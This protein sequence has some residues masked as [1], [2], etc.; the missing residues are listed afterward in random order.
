MV[1]IDASTTD[2]GCLWVAPE[3]HT[4]GPLPH[5]NGQMRD[6]DVQS[7]KWIPIE[8][9]PGDVMFFCAHT[10]HFS[11]ANNTEFSRRAMYLTYSMAKAGDLRESYYQDKREKFPPKHERNP[12]R[13]YTP[14]AAI[15]NLS[16]P[17]E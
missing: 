1:S 2:N 16:N 4:K 11:N 17:I 3:Q 5:P 14:G 15:Y 13:D 7:M 8:T 10:P 12:N 6:E 9:D